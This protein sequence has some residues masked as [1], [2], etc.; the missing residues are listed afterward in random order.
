MR[1]SILKAIIGWQAWKKPKYRRSIRSRPTRRQKQARPLL[2]KRNARRIRRTRKLMKRKP[3]KSPEQVRTNF[4]HLGIR[5]ALGGCY[6][7]VAYEVVMSSLL[8]E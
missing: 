8:L 7:W 2:P 6:A 3:Y 1:F 4:K 5:I